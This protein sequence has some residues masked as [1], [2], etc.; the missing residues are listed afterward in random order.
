MNRLVVRNTG[1]LV[2]NNYAGAAL[3]VLMV[4]I[5]ARLTS[6]EVVGIFTASQAIALL[7]FQSCDLGLM[8]IVTKRIARDRERTGALL[9]HLMPKR[10]LIGLAGLACVGIA[11]AVM[12]SHS[13]MRLWIVVLGAAAWL[14]Y[15]GD[16]FMAV[17]RGHERMDLEAW[18]RGGHLL[19]VAMCAAVLAWGWRTPSHT[20]AP[21]VI[22]GL[23]CFGP[24]LAKLL[25]GGW[26]LQRHTPWWPLRFER[27]GAEVFDEALPL[28]LANML[29]YVVMRVDLILLAVMAGHTPAGLY[30]P[31]HSLYRGAIIVWTAF[32]LAVF[33]HL[34]RK[35]LDHDG[36]FWAAWKRGAGWLAAATLSLM[37][38]GML[39]GADLLRLIYGPAYGAAGGALQCLAVANV[40]FAFSS[41]AGVGL[42]ALGRT[43]Q[44]L[45][46]HVVRM[47]I[48]LAA[49]SLLIPRFGVVGAAWGTLL[50]HV[51]GVVA[52]LACFLPAVAAHERMPVQALPLAANS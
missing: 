39:W 7:V 29:T 48:G 33:P 51:I 41:M 47:I 45:G 32:L 12:P 50:T 1:I 35:A 22:V 11:A 46:V 4:V 21:E 38:V 6:V 30:G 27:T 37:V 17:L 18:A 13:P 31:A 19:F 49:Y 16:L 2:L 20:P 15:L 52:V 34:S 28:G 40:A 26:L 10:A 24:G 3:N 9:R 36:Q 25:I 42:V 8:Q 14:E 44:L 23:M 43:R 5:L